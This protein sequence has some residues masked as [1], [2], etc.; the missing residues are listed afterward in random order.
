MTLVNAEPVEPNFQHPNNKRL[1]LLKERH[2]HNPCRHRYEND[3]QN[4][5]S[6]CIITGVLVHISVY[7]NMSTGHIS[8]TGTRS[9]D[10]KYENVNREI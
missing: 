1:H 4:A 5:R 2:T 7:N 9:N 6:R 3:N 10:V 8:S